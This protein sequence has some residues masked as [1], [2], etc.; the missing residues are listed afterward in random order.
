MNKYFN[1]QNCVYNII[2]YTNIIILFLNYYC[3]KLLSLD[4]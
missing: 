3:F 2:D 4:Q 1:E